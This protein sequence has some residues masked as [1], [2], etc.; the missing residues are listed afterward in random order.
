M[1]HFWKNHYLES[2]FH[3]TPCEHE[4]LER[5]KPKMPHYAGFELEK[6]SFSEKRAEL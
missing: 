3:G 5:E 6:G 1:S 4:W 2:S